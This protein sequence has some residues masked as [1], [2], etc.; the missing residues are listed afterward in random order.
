MRLGFAMWAVLFAVGCAS[1][2]S[3]Q[4]APKPEAPAAPAK[5][6]PAETGGP[7]AAAAPAPPGGVSVDAILDA[8]DRQGDQMKDFTADVALTESDELTKEAFTRAGKVQFQRLPD[9]DA[10]IH[11]V[12]ATKKTGEGQPKL[13]K[14]EYLLEKGWLTERNYRRQE[15]VRRQILKPGE[16]IDLLK[17]GEGPFPLP[18]G[19]AK[20]DVKQMFEVTVIPPAPTDPAGTVRG[21][22]KPKPQTQFDRRFGSIDVWVDPNA[23][24][25]RRI[26]TLD[27]NEQT[28]QTTDLENV[29]ANTG[30]TDAD[31]RLAPVN[32][33]DGWK[34]RDE[35][36]EE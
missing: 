4:D 17:L 1:K 22:L 30:L 14:I 10:R 25:P 7:A 3:A 32:A 12:F 35:P 18:I 19:Q 16:K 13:E 8:L 34:L 31:F 6:A 5:Q 33:K 23:Q 2:A 36:F 21:R 24:M 20:E 9:G 15:N 27:R 11:V 29:K 26:E 28:R